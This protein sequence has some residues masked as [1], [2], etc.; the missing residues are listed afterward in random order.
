[1]NRHITEEGW[2]SHMLLLKMVT[3]PNSSVVTVEVSPREDMVIES[4]D[5]DGKISPFVV[6]GVS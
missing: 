2:K 1:M 4:S 6:V 5:N 3:S